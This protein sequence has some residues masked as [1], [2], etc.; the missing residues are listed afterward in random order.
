LLLL[1]WIDLIDMENPAITPVPVMA[2]GEIKVQGSERCECRRG[3]MVTSNQP[4]KAL[5]CVIAHGCVYR[6]HLLKMSIAFGRSLDMT[7]LV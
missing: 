5:A 1:V 2:V 7:Y 6:S 4:I 3:V